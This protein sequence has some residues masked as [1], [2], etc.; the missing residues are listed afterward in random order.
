MSGGAGH[1]CKYRCFTNILNAFNNQAEIKQTWL[2]LVIIFR[3]CAKHPFRYTI[4]WCRSRDDNVSPDDVLTVGAA[5]HNS[6][7]QFAPGCPR[8]LDNKWK[9]RQ[10]INEWKTP[11]NKNATRVNLAKKKRR[12]VLFLHKATA[13]IRWAF[14]VIVSW[15]WFNYY[16]THNRIEH[17]LLA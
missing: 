10:K 17:K 9:R 3:G 8:I 13:L 12:R 6:P 16:L 5:S 15:T 11:E 1:L 7:F 4:W 2:I 14:F